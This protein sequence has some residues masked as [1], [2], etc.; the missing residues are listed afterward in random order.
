MAIQ[1]GNK[2]A[3]PYQGRFFQGLSLEDQASQSQMPEI[4]ESVMSQDEEEDE[5]GVQ[6]VKMPGK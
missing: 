6:I 5:F 1:R 3:K 4:A 2:N